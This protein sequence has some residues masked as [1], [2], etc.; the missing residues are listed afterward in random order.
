MSVLYLAPLRALL[1]NLLPRLEAYGSFVGRRVGLWHGDT[2]QAER[3]RMIT[4][5]PDVLLTTPESLEAMLISRRVDPTWMFAN[6]R[7]VVIDEVHAFAAA[8]R[9]WHLLAV[10]ERLAH[11]AERDLQRVGLSATVGNPDDLLQWLCGSSPVERQVINPPAEAVAEPEVTLD[12][13]GSL[14]NAATVIH[15][16]HRGEKRLVFVDS[17][18]RVEEL[19]VA[20][21]QKGTEVFVSHG[22]LG[23]DERRRSEQA[24]TEAHD[25]VIVST[26]TLELGIDVGD[27]DRV[28]QID[29]PPTVAGFLQRIGRT[30]RRSGSSRN[31]LFLATTDDALLTGAGLLRLWERG[32]VEPAEPPPL[33]A[34]LIAQQIL[35]LTLQEAD[36]GLGR[37]EWSSWIGSPPV[38]GTD[39]MSFADQVLQHLLD[40]EWLH[41]DEG[42][43]SPG[44]SAERAI[45]R[46]NFLE[47][48]SVFVA[49]PLVSVRQ[50]RREIGQ[51]PDVAITAAFAKSGGPPAILLAGRA[52]RIDNV[53][54]KRRVAQVE[55]VEHRGSIRFPGTTLPLSL[56]MCQ[57]VAALLEGSQLDEVSL[58]GR[59]AQR[60]NE[61]RSDLPGVRVGRTL[62]VDSPAGTRW[63]TFAGLRANLELAARLSPLR[64]QVT[65]RDNLYITLDG[66]VS[67]DAIRGAVAAATPAG[68]LA[69]LVGDVSGAL[70]LQRALP[71]WLVETILVR[72][73]EDRPAV[74]TVASQPIDT[75]T[76]A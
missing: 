49:D 5:P 4:D 45:G 31:A 55:P 48:T 73:L 66:R 44:T 7:A 21:R 14:S 76:V 42:L 13:V 34:H 12:Y 50:G 71:A 68:E 23:Q 46:K 52:W 19:A 30:G 58:T 75:L 6:L 16:L 47:L 27:L 11:F 70:K 9:G 39:A 64:S 59:A 36:S 38:F 18:R 41:D 20:L 43:L 60:L 63:Y 24:F 72:R 53:D 69:E 1:N 74:D 3:A 56:E 62:L 15:R 67:C 57:S 10:L 65:Q 8:D 22:S 33:P 61:I 54:W 51:V 37:A 2:S 28:I 26:S 35:A 29:S 17:R 40:T 25:C 32:Y